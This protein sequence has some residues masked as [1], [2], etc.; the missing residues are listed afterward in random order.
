MSNYYDDEYFYEEEL[1]TKDTETE[2]EE[3]ETDFKSSLYARLSPA[4]KETTITK[5]RI[6]KYWMVESFDPVEI[7]K[8]RR[9]GA[10]EIF[11]EEIP[12]FSYY[13][14]K[15]KLELNQLSYRRKVEKKEKSKEEREELRLRMKKLH[16]ARYIKQIEEFEEKLKEKGL[17]ISE[18]KELQEKI[19]NTKIKLENLYV[20]T[21][22]DDLLEEE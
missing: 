9:I 18:S 8:L 17:S 21:D 6:D 16:E 3:S 2:Q 4:E 14:S 15:F 7:R 19:Q 1:E 10:E 13:H 11:S 20:E 22:E 12:E 5:S